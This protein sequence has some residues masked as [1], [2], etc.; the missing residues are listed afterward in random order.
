MFPFSSIFSSFPSAPQLFPVSLPGLQ[1]PVNQFF[2]IF[3]D[4]WT[5][6]WG[7]L[8][9][10]FI[11]FFFCPPLA[12]SCSPPSLSLFRYDLSSIKYFILYAVVYL[13]L[14]MFNIFLNLVERL[15]CYCGVKAMFWF[16]VYTVI[17]FHPSRSV[18]CL[19]P[20]YYA[21][22]RSQS[23]YFYPKAPLN[24]PAGKLS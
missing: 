3:S 15:Q 11:Y 2:K 9:Y 8:I 12:R 21:T 6:T 1:V 19:L 22:S 24:F 16:A 4:T 14:F 20:C 10:T 23:F 5:R 13:K 17:F 7:C 18:F